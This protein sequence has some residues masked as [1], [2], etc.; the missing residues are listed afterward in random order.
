MS[1]EKTIFENLIINEKYSRAVLPFLKKEYFHDRNDQVVFSLIDQFITKYNEFP[2]KEA[3]LVELENK[4]DIANDDQFTECA[5]SINGFNLNKEV[6]TSTDWLLEQTE[7]F[8]QDKALF[9]AITEAI[10]I[11][12]DEK[13]SGVSKGV[14]PEL[15]TEALSVTFDTN[16]GHDYLSDTE[17]RFEFYHR[18]EERIPFDLDYF[19]KITKGGL[20]KKTLNMIIAPTGVGKSLI[21]C[22]MAAANLSAGLNVLYITL[23]MAEERIA[24]RIDANLLNTPLDE[25][26][27]LPKD[28]YD[29]RITR[30]KSKTTGKL[31]IKEYPTSCAGS[32][33][34]RHLLNELRIKKN[35]IPDIIYIDYLNICNSSRLKSAANVNSYT[36]VKTIAE[37]VRGL[38]VEFKL[39]IVSATQTNRGGFANS[40]IDLTNT[41]ESIG[42]PATVDM[43]FAVISNEEL[44]AINQFMIIQLKNRYSDPDKC[45]RFVIG[46]DKSRMLLYNL[47]ESAQSDIVQDVPQTTSTSKFDKTNFKDFK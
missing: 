39:P 34:F 37:E 10:N 29:K 21:M 24:E 19:N 28:V 36:Y 12:H 23:E 47:E 14:I 7:K 33:N 18:K 46:V 1:L 40:D 25:L 35:F 13:S 4:A 26:V 20:P 2:S 44:A 30:L 43:M 41:S 32:A 38:A 9:N 31:I 11:M 42:L 3:L 6:L 22:H 15:L 16:I 27:D 5:K 17:S 8:C 45:K